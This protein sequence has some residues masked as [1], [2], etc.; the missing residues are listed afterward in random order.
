MIPKI[1]HY[2]WFGN[3]KNQEIV[4]QINKWKL[5]L[6]D[7]LFYE[8]NETNFDLVN[9]PLYVKEALQNRK[10][11]FV[12]DYVRL[13][14]LYEYGG[15]YLDTDVEIIKTFDPLLENNLFLGFESF[16]ILCTAVIGSIPK[17]PIIKHFMEIYDQFRFIKPNKSLDLMPNTI[18]LFDFFRKNFHLKY[19]NKII[20]HK[21][22]I[23]YPEE[24]FSPKNFYTG[25]IITSEKTFTIHHFKGSWNK[26]KIKYIFIRLFIFLFGEKAY[27]NL[28]IK[29]KYRL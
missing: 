21:D 15:I 19:D 17:H 29:R 28:Y 3:E 2:C 6:K 12:T 16:N 4:N 10:W 1:I 8:W 14:V 27:Y 25:K 20:E 18:R 11:A 23:I 5:F 7:Y 22:Y 24:Y 9:T 13:K 26:S